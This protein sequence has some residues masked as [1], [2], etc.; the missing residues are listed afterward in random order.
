MNSIV[1]KDCQSRQGDHGYRMPR[2]H[3]KRWHS[4]IEIVTGMI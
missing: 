1:R 3:V 4:G 2:R